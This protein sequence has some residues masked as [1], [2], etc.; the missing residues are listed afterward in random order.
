[1][2]V[3]TEQSI[4]NDWNKSFK[5]IVKEHRPEQSGAVD[6]LVQEVQRAQEPPLNRPRIVNR[7]T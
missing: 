3:D 6:R 1:M 5:I 2:G 7:I 4:L